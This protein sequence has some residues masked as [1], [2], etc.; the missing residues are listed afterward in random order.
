[1]KPSKLEKLIQEANTE[2][3]DSFGYLYEMSKSDRRALKYAWNDARELINDYAVK[4]WQGR[5]NYRS[6]IDRRKEKDFPG[7]IYL[8][9]GSY[10][11]MPKKG[12]KAIPL[13]PEKNKNKIPGSIRKNNPGG[14]FWWIPH[15]NFR[16]RLVPEGEK[17]ATKDLKTAVKL[18]KQYWQD[19]QDNQPKL[20]KE[21]TNIRN[22]GGSTKHKPTAVKI[23]KKLWQ[24]MQEEQPM[25]AARIMSDKRPLIS[26]PDID[27]VWPDWTE[28]K[29]R[30]AFTNNKPKMPIVYQSQHIHSEWK[31]G[32]RPPSKL[33][34]TVD[35]VKNIDWLKKHAMVVFDDNAPSASKQIAIQSNGKYWADHNDR[36]SIQGST[37]I[38]K[39][40][41]RFRI[42]IYQPGF[43][44]KNVLT[45]EIYHIVYGIIGKS[46]KN[47]YDSTK[48]WYDRQLN[49]GADPSRTIEES[50][51]SNMAL[52]ENGTKTSLPRSV[53]RCA[54]KIFSDKASIDDTVIKE[55]KTDWPYHS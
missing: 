41:G 27:T 32:L 6:C 42:D 18:Q 24:K 29:A 33:E 12:E 13:I 5:D 37:C 19:I 28:E 15:K 36:Y 49:N 39:D 51:A 45:E 9:N 14:Y 31:H 46:D 35:K 50:F 7:T 48:R 8:N 55:V 16:Q 54:K 34:K 11:W 53:V 10:Y 3:L 21:L 25:K 44:D 47:I 38:D 22:R 2:G 20:A 17:T 23:A 1:M 52:E 4:L 26:K 43:N 40:T 30:L